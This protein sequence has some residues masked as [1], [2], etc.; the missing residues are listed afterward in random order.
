MLLRGGWARP[1]RRRLVLRDVRI[2]TSLL[3]FN[4]IFIHAVTHKRQ[5][6]AARC[7]AAGK[8]FAVC[9]FEVSGGIYLSEMKSVLK[10]IHRGISERSAISYAAAESRVHQRLS[11]TLQR[12]NAYSISLLPLVVANSASLFYDTKLNKKFH[13]NFILFAV[14]S[15]QNQQLLI[16]LAYFTTPNLIKNFILLPLVIA[17]SLYNTIINK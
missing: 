16:L 9:A 6:Y 17:G 8:L 5:H 12:S 4:F 13:F 10:R 14:A 2:R 1:G 11:F 15:F 3:H 7:Y